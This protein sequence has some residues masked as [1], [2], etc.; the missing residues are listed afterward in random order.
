MWEI[1]RLFFPAFRKSPWWSTGYVVAAVGA[2]AVSLAAPY[3]LGVMIDQLIA[4]AQGNAALN[5]LWP[6]FG[7]WMGTGLV[8]AALGSF[9]VLS[10]WTLMNVQYFD[11]NVTILGRIFS[12]DIALF[13]N[14]KSGEVNQVYVSGTEGMW[15]VNSRW[16]DEVLLGAV[17]FVVVLGIAFSFSWQMSVTFLFVVPFY[18][19]LLYRLYGKAHKWSDKSRN[20]WN[21]SFGLIGDVLQNI[22]A[23]KL[24]ARE[25]HEVQRIAPLLKKAQ[26]FQFK[27]NLIWSIADFFDAD[28]LAR[29]AVGAVGLHLV[30]Q[31][32]MSVGVFLMFMSYVSYLTNPMRMFAYSV[33]AFQK[34]VGQYRALK[35]IL[36]MPAP[37]RS[38]SGAYK[39]ASVQ[40]ALAFKQVS[41]SYDG[42]KE[43]LHRVSFTIQPGEHVALVGPS[44]AGKSTIAQLLARFY[45]PTSGAVTLDG[46]DVR[47]WDYENFR[48]H[49]SVVW[50][51]NMLFHESLEYN[52]RYG[53]LKAKKSAV[54]AAM[55]RA[56][57]TEFVASQKK[58]L[59]T[60][61]GERGVHLSGG[62]KQRVMIA[63]AV[64]KNADIVIL[65]E[66]TSALDSITE[67]AIQQSV[68][69][70]I[71]GK[72]AVIIAHRLSTIRAVD[73]IFVVNNGRIE[74]QGTHA[75]LLKCCA[76]YRSM[77][78]LQSNGLLQEAAP[79]K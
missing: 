8:G 41:F 72:T 35:E 6:T 19:L 66:A 51:E 27:Q 52:V 9:R 75:E 58:G 77:V 78:E 64:L 31:G 53:D 60:L 12:K 2:L 57:L 39:T 46:T 54:R 29:I 14:K 69:T 59:K 43:V 73:R 71:E 67:R 33:R 24:F 5:V 30:L 63:R 36:D 25:T 47:S 4:V 79:G 48:S 26:G 13:T 3:L 11:L 55:D 76:L 70:L 50:Q 17:S 42:T 28:M 23:V 1:L 44:G 38:V 32:A 49:F 74:A 22:F 7:L 20:A 15:S 18:V 40:G 21:A 16:Y 10:L 68:A 61:V 56:A 37:V 62:E 45:D 34:D 65:D